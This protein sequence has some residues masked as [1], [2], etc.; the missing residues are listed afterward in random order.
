[1][2]VYH[3]GSQK[4]NESMKEGGKKKSGPTLCGR[5]TAMTGTTGTTGTSW[6]ALCRD[7]RENRVHAKQGRKPPQK[8]KRLG[9]KL[10]RKEK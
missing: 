6:D 10:T 8:K 9:V 2:C 3:D 1:M 7:A 5:T 4:P